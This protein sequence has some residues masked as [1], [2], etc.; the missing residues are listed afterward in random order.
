[1]TCEEGLVYISLNDELECL[2]GRMLLPDTMVVCVDLSKVLENRSQL[3]AP[4][5]RMKILCWPR[6]NTPPTISIMCNM[7]EIEN[8]TTRQI[9]CRNY[10]FQVS[11]RLDVL[12]FVRTTGFQFKLSKDESRLIA[13]ILQS[14]MIDSY[15]LYWGDKKDSIWEGCCRHW[16]RII[17]KNEKLDPFIFDDIPEYKFMYLHNKNF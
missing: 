9:T 1:M 8:M 2:R 3:T 14:P 5:G 11:I 16:N 10:R 4:M 17:T 6:P 12:R 15:S 7:S 13:T